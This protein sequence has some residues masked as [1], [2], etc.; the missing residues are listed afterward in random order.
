MGEGPGREGYRW[1]PACITPLIHPPTHPP[2]TPPHPRWSAPNLGLHTL[3]TACA[4]HLVR[5]RT[6]TPSLFWPPPYPRPSRSRP[7]VAP[8]TPTPT[9]TPT[10]TPVA[11]LGR[12]GRWMERHWLH[13]PRLLDRHQVHLPQRAQAAHHRQLWHGDAGVVSEQLTT[14]TGRRAGGLGRRRAGGRAA[15]AMTTSGAAF[16]WRMVVVVSAWFCGGG[17]RAGRRWQAPWV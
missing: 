8:S 12:L 11:W 7:P 10:P 17:G 1:V 13:V 5:R 3:P 9:L 16:D 6:P 15:A 4:Q 14:H 2:A